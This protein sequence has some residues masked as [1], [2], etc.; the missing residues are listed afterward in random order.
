MTTEERV[1]VPLPARRLDRV[2]VTIVERRP[3]SRDR[4]VHERADGAARL[5]SRETSPS[6][7]SKLPVVAHHARRD[8]H[9]RD[10]EEALSRGQIAELG[11]IFV[12][13]YEGADDGRVRVADDPGVDLIV[14]GPERHRTGGDSDRCNPVTRLGADWRGPDVQ[15]VAERMTELLPGGLEGDL[16]RGARGEGQA[17]NEGF[18]N[19][20][21]RLHLVSLRILAPGAAP[22]ASERCKGKTHAQPRRRLEGARR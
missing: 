17:E 13:G 10:R 15:H 14:F 4:G 6:R 22:A 9:G 7:L 11:M 2:L 21:W 8:Q 18:D 16:G 19:D 12:E 1:V 20:L 5:P 3:L